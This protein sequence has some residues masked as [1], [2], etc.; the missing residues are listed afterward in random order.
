MPPVPATGTEEAGRRALLYSY[1]T[2]AAPSG[3][4]V[5]LAPILGSVIPAAVLAALAA[6]AAV[7]WWRRRRERRKLSLSPSGRARLPQDSDA[8]LT[9][10]SSGPFPPNMENVEE[11]LVKPEDFKILKRKDGSDWLLGQGAF[12]KARRVLRPLPHLSERQHLVS[13]RSPVG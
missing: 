13:A 2:A 1:A 9:P 6:T 5:P 3:Q 7:W 4:G 12:G 11:Y 10:N 8:I